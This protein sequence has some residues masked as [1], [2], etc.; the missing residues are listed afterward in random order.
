MIPGTQH[1]LLLQESMGD[2]MAVAFAMPPEIKAEDLESRIPED[3][4]DLNDDSPVRHR[5]RGWAE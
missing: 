4:N 5:D 2:R 1:I 3:P